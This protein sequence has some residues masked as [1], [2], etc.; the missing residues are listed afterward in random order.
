MEKLVNVSRNGLIVTWEIQPGAIEPGV[1]YDIFLNAIND[2]LNIFE[3]CLCGVKSKTRTSNA[4]IVEFES[5]K[6]A[7]AACGELLV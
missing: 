1:Y 4:L 5:E 6:L 2:A 7:K 3:K